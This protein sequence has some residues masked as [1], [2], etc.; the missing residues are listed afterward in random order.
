MPM[1]SSAM[2]PQSIEAA[3]FVTVPWRMNEIVRSAATMP[4]GR[5]T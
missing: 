5:F 3:R 2:P 4:I 1:I